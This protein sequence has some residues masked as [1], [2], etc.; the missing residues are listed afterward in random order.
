MT[1]VLRVQTLT[2]GR[3]PAY[4]NVMGVDQGPA[5]HVGLPGLLRSCEV[6]YPG[7]MY[8]STNVEQKVEWVRGLVWVFPLAAGLGFLV[9]GPDLW[10]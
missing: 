9:L 5:V 1:A 3:R 2:R 10:Q 4:S 8:S 7:E 6:R